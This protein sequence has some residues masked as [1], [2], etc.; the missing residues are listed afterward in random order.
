MVTNEEQ[1]T[2]T[3]ETTER[4]KLKV[5]E[6]KNKLGSPWH[7]LEVFWILPWQGLVWKYWRRKVLKVLKFERLSYRQTDSTIEKR[8]KRITQEQML[9]KTG[10]Y[11]SKYISAEMCETQNRTRASL[12][13][14]NAPPNTPLCMFTWAAKSTMCFLCSQV[15]SHVGVMEVLSYCIDKIWWWC[16]R[17]N[18]SSVGQRLLP[19]L[20]LLLKGY[21]IHCS[22]TLWG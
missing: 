2:G 18:L 9:G 11:E 19:F 13:V 14:V 17:G 7:Q 3:K 21:K 1:E 5:Y 12:P 4:D 16:C 10:A 20:P 22:T 15:L 6:N 8:E